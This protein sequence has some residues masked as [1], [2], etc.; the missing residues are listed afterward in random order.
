VFYPRRSTS[1]VS[2]GQLVNTPSEEHGIAIAGGR[3]IATAL[4]FSLH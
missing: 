3:A 1:L 4:A 2:D